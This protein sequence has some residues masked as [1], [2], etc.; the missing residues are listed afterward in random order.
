MYCT[1]II[2]IAS[3]HNICPSSSLAEYGGLMKLTVTSVHVW[4]SNY[5]TKVK[6]SPP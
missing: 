4:V 6:E 1:R 5:K 2:I 3:I